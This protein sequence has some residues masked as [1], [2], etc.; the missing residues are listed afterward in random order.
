MCNTTRATTPEEDVIICRCEGVT[1]GQ[2]RQCVKSSSARTV[3][4]IK[5]LTRSGMGMCQGRTCAGTVALILEKDAH[6]PPGVE[7]SH[8]R[9]PVRPVLLQDLAAGSNDFREPAGPVSV[10]MLRKPGDDPGRT[11][12]LENEQ[13]R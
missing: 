4:E 5:K 6:I 11:H 2:I 7:P 8:A 10:I 3:N 13:N 12:P 1:L 9:P